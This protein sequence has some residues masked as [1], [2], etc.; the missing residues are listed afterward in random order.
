MQSDELEQ[1]IRE[2]RAGYLAWKAHHADCPTCQAWDPEA[3]AHAAVLAF[4]ERE[5]RPPTIS[6]WPNPQDPCAE[7]RR[8]MAERLHRNEAASAA[9]R[10]LGFNSPTAYE[11]AHGAVK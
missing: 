11:R 4:E 2:R 6:E 5:G 10:A 9:A 1:L 8:L 7:S 3:E